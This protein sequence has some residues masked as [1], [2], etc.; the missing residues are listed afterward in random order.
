[1]RVTTVVLASVLGMIT[2]SALVWSL[3]PSGG[4]RVAEAAPRSDAPASPQVAAPDVTPPAAPVITARTSFSVDGTLR[5][6]GRLGHPVLAEQRVDETYLFVNLAAEVS[7]PSRSLTPADVTIVLDRSGSMRGSRMDTALAAARGMIASLRDGDTIS[8]I[9]YDETA[10]VLVPPTR[11]DP[12]TR[13]QVSAAVSTVGASGSTCLSCGV[14][15]ALGL[16]QRGDQSVHR[17]LLLSDGKANRGMQSMSEFGPMA[18]M[19]RDAQISVSSIGVGT[20]YDERLLSSLSR[21]T[22]GFHYF[23]EHLDQLGDIFVREM[24]AV[25]KTVASAASVEVTLAPGVEVLEVVDRNSTRDGNRVIIPFG[26]F[27]AGEEKTLL[28]RVRL[29]ASAAGVQAVGGIAVSYL[30][31]VTGRHER[32]NGALEVQIGGEKGLL[33]PTVEARVA[34]TETVRSLTRVNDLIDAGR[35]EEARA[36]LDASRSHIQELRA[37]AASRGAAP[38]PSADRNFDLQEQALEEATKNV[39]EAE[40]SRA[41]GARD[42][43][44][45]R[46]AASKRNMELLNPFG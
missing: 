4:P 37:A 19:A 46:K 14:E 28:M 43:P 44:V 36:A 34:Q 27:T 42:A 26:A 22:N 21:G 13:L 41:E 33:D 25:A 10:E 8:L 30:D 16:V 38:S 11:I 3:S 12:R 5:V 1:M 9:A 35:D 32:A 17:V 31:G 20:D 6:S 29:P 24:D 40:R 23:V 2:S 39:D 15:R 18:R 45:K 7:K